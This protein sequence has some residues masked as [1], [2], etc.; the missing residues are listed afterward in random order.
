ME[1]EVDDQAELRDRDAAFEA[2]FMTC[3]DVLERLTDEEQERFGALF[4]AFR[5][6]FASIPGP[7]PAGQALVDFYDAKRIDAAY[8]IVD[9]R[10]GHHYAA[11]AKASAEFE[12]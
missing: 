7:A 12:D 8:R 4:A 5:E 2:Q 6:E 9:A 10:A 11:E 1:P 3:A